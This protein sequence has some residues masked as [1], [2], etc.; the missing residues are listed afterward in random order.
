[1]NQLRCQFKA[2]DDVNNVVSDSELRFIP[3]LEDPPRTIRLA[4]DGNIRSPN[5]K[6]S[7]VARGGL[8]ESFRVDTEIPLTDASGNAL[9]K[10]PALHRKERFED[11][12]NPHTMTPRKTNRSSSLAPRI[13][14]SML[15]KKAL[16]EAE[17]AAKPD[18]LTRAER[19]RAIRAKIQYYEFKR[20]QFRAVRG[21]ADSCTDHVIES[22]LKERIGMARPA[23]R[24]P[25]TP[26][27]KISGTSIAVRYLEV[28]PQNSKCSH[29]S[30]VE[31]DPASRKVDKP[32]S[33]SSSS[34]PSNDEYRILA[35]DCLQANVT[36]GVEEQD[37]TD[38]RPPHL[39]IRVS[40]PSPVEVTVEPLSPRP[41]ET[42]NANNATSETIPDQKSTFS[43]EGLRKPSPVKGDSDYDFDKKPRI[44][45]MPSQCALETRG[46]VG[47]DSKTASETT[48]AGVREEEY[49]RRDTADSGVVI[50][51]FESKKDTTTDTGDKSH[52][53]GPSPLSTRHEK[54]STPGDA[55]RLRPADTIS[56]EIHSGTRRHGIV[57]ARFVSSAELQQSPTNRRLTEEKKRQR[58]DV[59]SSRTTPTRIRSGNV[60]SQ[61]MLERTAD[62]GGVAKKKEEK[63]SS[64]AVRVAHRDERIE[65]A[66]RYPGISYF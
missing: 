9:Q 19:Y 20:Q 47:G 22:T 46:Q 43:D 21:V 18:T 10:Y 49:N 65:P 53:A 24:P 66:L 36:N 40:P 48:D 14:S 58:L 4:E 55:P 50:A 61:I 45:L 11:L 17:F 31:G 44:L 13:D 60:D 26:R 42:D 25:V 59:S 35:P 6:L 33:S 29:H 12:R 23:I 2:M 3:G 39:S 1:M 63:A 5:A 37:K 30:A 32:G 41:V 7:V 27:P 16:A 52:H 8:D 15:S 51:V 56:P 64:G 62:Q 54:C 38:S 28:H 34:C 57:I